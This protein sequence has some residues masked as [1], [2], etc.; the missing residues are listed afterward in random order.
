LDCFQDKY[1][2][3]SK[4]L[5][6]AQALAIKGIQQKTT[7]ESDK[8]FFRAIYYRTLITF[9]DVALRKANQAK[10]WW[11]FFKWA[12]EIFQSDLKHY[13]AIEAIETGWLREAGDAY[14]NAKGC[15]NRAKGFVEAEFPLEIPFANYYLAETDYYSRDTVG[16]WRGQDTVKRG[17]RQPYEEVNLD[18]SHTAFD[19]VMAIWESYF[20]TKVHN[21]LSARVDYYQGKI[22]QWQKK[23][24]EAERL[25]L[26]A[27]IRANK[28]NDSILSAHIKFA[29]GQLHSD[30]ALKADKSAAENEIR[31]F[32]DNM[33]KALIALNSFGMQIEV[34]DAIAFSLRRKYDHEI[35]MLNI[36]P[37]LIELFREHCRQAI[38]HQYER[39]A[40]IRPVDLADT[41][42]SKL[43]P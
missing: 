25:L 38:T 18:A 19:T 32:R 6:K 15:F 5:E 35:E 27:Q 37:D 14:E 9:G 4:R 1:D 16:H 21:R 39:I 24:S 31:E 12:K 30:I 23:Y 20:G 34:V 41:I 36:P 33:G 8:S 3:S 29:L 28:F 7:S 17:H 2:Q 11:R 13:N 43:L 40:P 42:L 10:N 22:H 26:E